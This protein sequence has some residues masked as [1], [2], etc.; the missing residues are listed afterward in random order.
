MLL[1]RPALGPPVLPLA[2]FPVRGLKTPLFLFWEL[3]KM[4]DRNFS[5]NI[6]PTSRNSG[7]TCQQVLNWQLPDVPWHLHFLFMLSATIY[8][9]KNIW[10]KRV[11]K[12]KKSLRINRATEKRHYTLKNINNV[13]LTCRPMRLLCILMRAWISLGDPLESSQ[14]LEKRSPKRTSWLQ[15]PHSQVSCMEISSSGKGLS[16]ADGWLERRLVGRSPWWLFSSG[17]NDRTMPRP[18]PPFCR[19]CS[20]NCVSFSRILSSSWRRLASQPHPRSLPMLQAEATE[21]A[22]PA[23]NK[24]REKA[25][26]RKPG[27]RRYI[28]ERLAKINSTA[29]KQSC[30]SVQSNLIWPS[31][32]SPGSHPCWG[33]CCGGEVFQSPPGKSSSS[34]GPGAVAGTRGWP[35]GCPAERR[36]SRLGSA[37]TFASDAYWGLPA[38]GKLSWGLA[39]DLLPPSGWGYHYTAPCRE[40]DGGRVRG[41]W[42]GS[43]LLVR[44]SL[45]KSREVCSKMMWTV[46]DRIDLRRM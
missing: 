16:K 24:A 33:W 34:A 7:D 23:A 21:W 2:P 32:A 27:S 5:F 11:R 15:P 28:L 29:L 12:A 20:C 35:P 6:E 10:C 38:S 44:S 36:P 22:T 9:E 26:S 39:L 4:A 46:E 17:G 41:W 30:V 8:T 14:S 3:T 1:R 18:T 45:V 13:P 40:W 25:L 37:H 43:S 42:G 31:I 19:V